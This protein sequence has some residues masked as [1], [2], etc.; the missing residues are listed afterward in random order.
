MSC[1][2][3]F[4]SAR[5]TRFLFLIIS[6]STLRVYL[7]IFVLPFWRGFCSCSFNHQ[8]WESTRPFLF[9][10]FDKLFVLHH[11][12]WESTCLLCSASLTSFLFLITL[13][14]TLRVYLPVFV[15][16]VWQAFCSSSLYH[17]LW[18]L[19]C[20]F[21]FCQSD[22]LFDPRHFRI[23][24]SIDWRRS[25]DHSK[26]PFWS[27]N[28]RSSSSPFRNVGIPFLNRYRSHF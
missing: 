18:E 16:P 24:V 15:L 14:S 2:A 19:T 28:L 9:C 13:L 8:L 22:E 10:Q 12:I 7:P 1:L 20:L 6:S 23:I 3:W 4:C 26:Q 5:L 27:L 25:I 17:Q 21:L 11:Q